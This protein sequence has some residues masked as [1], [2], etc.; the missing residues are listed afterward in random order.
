MFVSSSRRL[1]PVSSRYASSSVGFVNEIFVTCNPFD[2]TSADEVVARSRGAAIALLNKTPMPAEVLAQLPELKYI[3][4]LAT[5]YNV[6]DTAAAREHGIV[7]TNVPTYGTA[8]VAQFVFALLLSKIT[9]FRATIYGV[10]ILFVVYYLPD[11][12]VG[13][14]KRIVAQIKPGW[15]RRHIVIEAPAA[16]ADAWSSAA[17]TAWSA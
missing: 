1:L 4:V 13:F 17:A 14:L 10:M 16:V 5:G 15:T 2:R 3:G 6:V 12:I 9:D 8:S 11:G 7:V